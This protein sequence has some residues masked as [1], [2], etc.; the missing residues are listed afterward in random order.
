MKNPAL[1][2]QQ[3]DTIIKIMDDLIVQ[4]GWDASGFLRVVGKKLQDI[5][6][7]FANEIN[8]GIDNKL[9]INATLA[10]RV[11]M[12]SGQQEVF[13]ALYCS[14]GEKMPNWERMVVNLPRQM[15]SRPIYANEEDVIAAGRDKENKKNDAY[16]SFYI[17]HDDVLPLGDKSPQDKLGKPLLTLKDKSLTL[18]NINRFVH[19]SGTYYYTQGRLVKSTATDA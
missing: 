15:T 7:K 4:P 18:E 9:K 6:D 19:S 14:E 17:N 13:I 12:R 8:G 3:T 16:V 5:R 11:A 10:N 1:S 2:K